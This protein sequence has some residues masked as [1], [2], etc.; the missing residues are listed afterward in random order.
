M[1]YEAQA[2][3]VRIALMMSSL[4]AIFVIAKYA[5]L[6]L[7]LM[8]PVIL[9][10]LVADFVVWRIIMLK[11]AQKRLVQALRSS[12]PQTLLDALRSVGNSAVVHPTVATRLAMAEAQM[13][14]RQGRVTEALERLDRLSA[15]G[16]CPIELAPEVE[17]LK[18]K[19]A[20]SLTT[21]PTQLPS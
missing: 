3:I 7:L 4:A 8:I 13:L 19:C 20:Q 1:K 16:L 15:A 12:D 9:F 2:R 17:R 11:Q 10:M 18:E 6:P 14:L 5:K 21:P